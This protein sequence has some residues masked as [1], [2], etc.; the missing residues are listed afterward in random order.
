MDLA[1]KELERAVDRLGMVGLIVLANVNETAL[2]DPRFDPFWAALDERRLPVLLHPTVPP[3]IEAVS[4]MVD[5]FENEEGFFVSSRG[6][7]QPRAGGP[8]GGIQ[9][10]G[11]P[12]RAGGDRPGG[13]GGGDPPE[14]LLTT[15]VANELLSAARAM[16]LAGQD[17]GAV[18]D[19]LAK[20][21]GAPESRKAQGGQ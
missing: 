10:V 4:G 12:S 18:F 19:V 17:C 21:S 7:H 9:R 2:D 20:M 5:A 3:G 8:D 1:L 16:G 14:P 13:G 11:P 15:A 6:S